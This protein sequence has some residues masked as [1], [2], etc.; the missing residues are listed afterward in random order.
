MIYVRELYSVVA[1]LGLSSCPKSIGRST[2]IEDANQIRRIRLDIGWG[3]D[4]CRNYRSLGGAVHGRRISHVGLPRLVQSAYTLEIFR[5]CLEKALG[6]Y[7]VGTSLWC[8]EP[9]PAHITLNR[10]LRHEKDFISS[11]HAEAAGILLCLLTFL[12]IWAAQHPHRAPGAPACVHSDSYVAVKCWNGHLGRERL[13]PYLR[14]LERLCA[15]YNI[16]L[17]VKFVPGAENRIADLI[18]RQDGVMTA[19]LR[20]LFPEANEAPLR[21]ISPDQLFL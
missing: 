3:L 6:G 9:I 2:F 1:E 15:F 11:G 20:Q 7:W 17:H 18:S 19:E 21:V 5:I 13:L 12:P 10:N 14:V 8:Y 16:Q 4:L